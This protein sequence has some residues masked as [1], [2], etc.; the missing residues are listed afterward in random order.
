MLS[1]TNIAAKTQLY[2]DD[3][4]HEDAEYTACEDKEA[5]VD[6]DVLAHRHWQH[7]ELLVNQRA[8]VLH[9]YRTR[10]KHDT[11]RTVASIS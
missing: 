11:R 8:R 1:E 4:V 6:C 2:R 9:F 5:R 3:N 10:L 7:T